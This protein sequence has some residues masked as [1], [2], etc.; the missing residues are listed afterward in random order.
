MPD[1]FYHVLALLGLA[2]MILIP[3]GAII[4]YTEYR[5]IYYLRQ[6]R[7][8]AAS[9]G[10]FNLFVDQK[11]HL[12]STDA[13]KPMFFDFH[14]ARA[15]VMPPKPEVVAWCN[16]FTKKWFM[17]P[18]MVSARQSGGMTTCSIIVFDDPNDAVAFK[19]RWY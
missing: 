12:L 15:F 16:E 5:Y 17:M 8:R 3:I 11:Y 19:M 10:S 1:I 2:I 7:R 13:S 4:A 6:L 14:G 18:E 9:G